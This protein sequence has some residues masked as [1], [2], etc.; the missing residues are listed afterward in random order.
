VVGA[1][2]TGSTVGD[3]WARAWMAGGGIGCQREDWVA[4]SDED[5]AENRERR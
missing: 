5:D 3:G 2:S 1:V 4:G